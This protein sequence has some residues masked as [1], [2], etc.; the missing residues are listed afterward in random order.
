MWQSG[1]QERPQRSKPRW[2]RCWREQCRQYKSGLRLLAP[3][4]KAP[5][6]PRVMRH[7]MQRRPRQLPQPHP[8]TS[9][10][11]AQA[12][13][14]R[15]AGKSSAVPAMALSWRISVSPPTWSRRY[16]FPRSRKDEQNESISE[17][18]QMKV[19]VTNLDASSS[20]NPDTTQ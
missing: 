16:Q 5:E 6:M 3:M 19:Q 8:T 20:T 10:I 2:R 18:F 15:T 11:S 7:R 12:K 4:F 9:S 13:H 17:S 14:S 1:K